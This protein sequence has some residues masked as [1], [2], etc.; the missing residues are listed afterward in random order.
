MKLTTMNWKQR[1]DRHGPALLLGFLLLAAF[2]LRLLGIGFDLPYLMHPDEDAVIMPAINILKTGDWSPTR[3][4]YGT[5]HVYLLTA[6]FATVFALA[7]QDGRIATVD[8]LPLFERGTIPAV[9]ANPEY[10]VAARLVS[11]VFG[12]LFVL[13]VYM[14]GR[15]LGNQQ[16]GLIAAAV[17]AFL[18]AL[19]VNDHF[20]TT[21]SA[22]MFWVALSLYLLLRTYDNWENND[23]LAYAG[24]GFVCGLAA[25]TKYN[26]IVLAVPL[27]LV[28]L[29]R[30]RSL[31]EWLSW[32]VIAGPLAMLGGFLAGTPYALLDLPKFLYWFGY[33]LHLYA[34]PGREATM[35]VWL[36]HLRHHLTN[37]HMPIIVLGVIGLVLSF[38][39]WGIKRAVIVNSFAV[40]LWIAILGQSN[41]QT[42]MWLP[43]ASL[44]IL[45]A[46]LV[47]DIL[48]SR[49][50]KFLATR[51]RDTR[52]AY[53]LLLLLLLP[54]LYFSLRYDLNFRQGD[55]R[56]LAREWVEA[57]VPPGTAVAVD[58]FHPNLDP[59]I[60]PLTRT[61][62]I[63]EHDVQWYVDNG[64][65]YLV[66]NEA[67]IDFGQLSAEAYGRY[68][69]LLENVCEVGRVNGP[70]VATTEV[71]IKIYRVEPCTP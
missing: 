23:W 60:W 71:A 55:V 29:F 17:A 5:F 39:H 13:V 42:R 59:A 57:N 65:E 45:W 2:G 20:A 22:L 26:G 70:F 31:D 64:I 25:S 10:F 63:F 19:V 8:Q 24:A 30:A 43:G 27:L 34:A 12:T 4:E 41:A 66:L 58:Y 37:P 54:F 61:F 56:T 11:A 46:A 3:M 69:T 1:L 52:W 15:R 9:Y 67:L 18:P 44:F 32:R 53:G 21:D 51:Q 16:Q 33:S 38:W 49:V 48:I 7:A 36:W 62:F 50:G 28:P 35:P 6:V 68:Q 47:L 40:V 14:L